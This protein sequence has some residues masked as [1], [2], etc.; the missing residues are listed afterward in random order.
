MSNADQ[1][2]NSPTN[3]K[4]RKLEALSTSND[5]KQSSSPGSSSEEEVHDLTRELLE[6][7]QIPIQRN[8]SQNG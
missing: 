7:F 3:S 1:N 2:S 6:L 5:E 8:K 4:E